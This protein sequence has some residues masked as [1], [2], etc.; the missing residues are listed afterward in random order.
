VSERLGHSGI[1]LTL[2]TYSHVLPGMQK[3]ASE[4]IDKRLFGAS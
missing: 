4:V 2:D 3:E 1:A